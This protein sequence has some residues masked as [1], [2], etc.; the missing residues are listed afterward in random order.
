[1]NHDANVFYQSVFEQSSCLR[2]RQMIAL[3]EG[4]LFPEEVRAV[5]IHLADCN[6]CVETLEGLKSLAGPLETVLEKIPTPNYPDVEIDSHVV[7]TPPSPILEANRPRKQRSIKLKWSSSLTLLLFLISGVAFVYFFEIKPNKNKIEASVSSTNNN[8]DYIDK[9][10]VES[11]DLINSA[12]IRDMPE[13]IEHIFSSDNIENSLQNNEEDAVEAINKVGVPN[14]E[15][16]IVAKAEEPNTPLKKESTQN[17]SEVTK[18][19]TT[20]TVADKVKKENI[21][22]NSKGD[23]TQKEENIKGATVTSSDQGSKGED[24][25]YAISFYENGSYGTALLYFQAVLK[26]KSHPRYT[27]ALYYA[28]LSQQALGRNSEVKKLLNELK[29]HPN[30]QKYDLDAFN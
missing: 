9:D 2:K 18:E 10:Y 11:E 28:A 24:F 20:P 5:E 13:E 22:N 25:N 29:K 19:E 4:R 27:D 6:L 21:V 16:E 12:V 1:M 7:Y 14:A 17:P 23:S 30:Y 8:Q 26:N 15:K 3:L